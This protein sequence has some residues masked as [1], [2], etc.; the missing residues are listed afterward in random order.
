VGDPVAGGAAPLARAAIVLVW[1]AP[2]LAAVVTELGHTRL[3]PGEAEPRH[4]WP[5]RGIQVRGRRRHV[6]SG[7]WAAAA[8]SWRAG[9]GGGWFMACRQQ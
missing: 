5:R 1:G 2:P 8:G 7:A 6:V 3:P 4:G 9:N